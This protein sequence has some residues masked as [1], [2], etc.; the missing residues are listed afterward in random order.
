ME[1]GRCKAGRSVREEALGELDK[2]LL[3]RVF[4]GEFRRAESKAS[5]P[6]PSPS[7]VGGEQF[8]GGPIEDEARIR[9]ARISEV[10]SAGA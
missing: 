5:D 10:V 2:R 8:G 6:V 4:L 7:P 1:Q 9:G 3:H